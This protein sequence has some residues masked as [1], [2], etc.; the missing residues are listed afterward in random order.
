MKHI[1]LF[2][3]SVSIALGGQMLSRRLEKRVRLLQKICVLF[4]CV[5]TKIEFTA[6]SAADIFSY[7]SDCGDFDDLLFIKK[8][9]EALA[10]GESFEDAWNRSLLNRENAKEL[11]KGDLEV[12]LSFGS[13]FGTTDVAGQSANC[14]LHIKLAEDKLEN[15]KKEL[16]LYSK[17]VRSLGILFA[18][19]VY[20]IFM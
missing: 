10:R 16:E 15:A 18:A 12:L 19:A 6:Q 5:C 8:C 1:A 14:K 13:L 11:K 7:L 9:A 3:V 2:I 17:P 20:I 4:S